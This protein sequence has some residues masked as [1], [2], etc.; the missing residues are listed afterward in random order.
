[1]NF[2]RLIVSCSLIIIPNSK[3]SQYN[4][5]CNLLTLYEVN[6]LPEYNNV[7]TWLYCYLLN[8]FLGVAFLGGD[9]DGVVLAGV[10]F[11]NLGDL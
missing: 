4:V 6:N 3:Y 8:S 7:Y 2:I 11:D 9:F 10:V 1:M 5:E